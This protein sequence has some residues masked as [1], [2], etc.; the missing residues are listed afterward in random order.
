MIPSIIL[1]CTTFASIVVYMYY[2][3]VT[4]VDSTIGDERKLDPLVIAIYTTTLANNGLC[5][6]E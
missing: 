2:M 1:W 4:E 6:G 5:T 3:G